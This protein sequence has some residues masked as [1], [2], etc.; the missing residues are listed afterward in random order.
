M[1]R[2][3]LPEADKEQRC[4]A[5]FRSDCSCVKKC[6]QP[7]PESGY[8]RTLKVNLA[9]QAHQQID[10]LDLW[11][12]RRWLFGGIHVLIGQVL[13]RVS[14]N[15]QRST[16]FW[17]DPPSPVLKRNP[18]NS[19]AFNSRANVD[20]QSHLRTPSLLTKISLLL[21]RQQSSMSQSPQ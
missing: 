8:N 7:F 19:S 13:D 9:V 12:A 1:H 3:R 21:L 6:K 20:R 18:M 11:I 10:C 17:G 5:A 14:Q 2:L 16:S 15:L 4:F